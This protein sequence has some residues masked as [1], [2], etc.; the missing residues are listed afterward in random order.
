MWCNKYKKFRFDRWA[1]KKTVQKFV[2]VQY[3]ELDCCYTITSLYKA[4]L[5]VCSSDGKWKCLFGIQRTLF[6][7]SRAGSHS[8]SFGEKTNQKKATKTAFRPLSYKK[9]K[10][11]QKTP[12]H[13]QHYP[14][15]WPRGKKLQHSLDSDVTTRRRGIH[16]ET[17]VLCT[18]YIH[19]CICL[20]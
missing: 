19:F 5:W 15:F 16:F 12:K 7:Q 4:Q 17:L 20:T 13:A 3:T 6:A 11:K 14:R 1:I 10:T 18:F 2:F 8:Y 9:N